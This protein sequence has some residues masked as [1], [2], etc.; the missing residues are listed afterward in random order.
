MSLLSPNPFVQFLNP[1]LVGHK[2]RFAAVGAAL[3]HG[4]VALLSFPEADVGVVGAF[5]GLGVDVVRIFDEAAAV[6]THIA[7]LAV[8]AD[9]DLVFADVPQV[10]ESWFIDGFFQSGIFNVTEALS[11]G[12]TVLDVA[13]RVNAYLAVEAGVVRICLCEELLIVNK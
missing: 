9:I 3:L 6:G 13:L 7:E 2:P 12:W 4:H 11:H 8:L 10:F 1:L 5:G